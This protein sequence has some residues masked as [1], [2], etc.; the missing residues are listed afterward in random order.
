MMIATLKFCNCAGCD[1]EILGD[2]FA[3]WYEGAAPNIK[4]DFPNGAVAARIKGRPYCSKCVEE[5]ESP[6][7]TIVLVPDVVPT[8]NDCVDK[9]EASIRRLE[10]NS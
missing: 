3:R 7:P 4:K 2:S 6:K 5:E 1:K 8:R 9:L 10:A